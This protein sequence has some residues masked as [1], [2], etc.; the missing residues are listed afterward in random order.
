MSC[1]DWNCP[2]YQKLCRSAVA[3]GYVVAG[4]DISEA[5]KIDTQRDVAVPYMS[6]IVHANERGA[7]DH[8]ASTVSTIQKNAPRKCRSDDAGAV[9]FKQRV[10][11]DQE[12]SGGGVSLH[13]RH[14]NVR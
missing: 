4:S 7:S 1:A 2:W 13:D 8:P 3:A 5:P 6:R 10:E 14:L 9:R 11:V 12:K